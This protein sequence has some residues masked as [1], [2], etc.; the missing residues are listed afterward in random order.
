MN[1]NSSS[2]ETSDAEEKLESAHLNQRKKRK[3]IG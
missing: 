2:T 1:D 3:C